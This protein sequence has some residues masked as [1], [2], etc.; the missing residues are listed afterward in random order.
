MILKATATKN[1]SSYTYIFIFL[2]SLCAPLYGMEPE[3]IDRFHAWLPACTIR[4]YRCNV[5]LLFARA[6]CLT[7]YLEELCQKYENA[8]EYPP[9]F[10]RGAIFE[11]PPQQAMEESP[12]QERQ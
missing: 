8:E 9:L 3:Q 7:C 11:S 4:G 5:G 2:A 12:V 1:N 6:A 10:A